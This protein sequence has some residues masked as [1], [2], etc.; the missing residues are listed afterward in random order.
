MGHRI[1]PLRV[2]LDIP[3]VRSAAPGLFFLLL[4]LLAP[5]CGGGSSSDPTKSK[6]QW[7]YAPGSL[8]LR[9]RADKMLNLYDAQG[10]TL[11]L[12]IYQLSDPNGFN[13]LVKTETGLRKLLECKDFDPTAVY[14]QQ[15]IVQPGEDRVIP[16]DR[17]EKATFVAV[18]A[19]YYE[20]A[21][22]RSTR[23]FQIPVLERDEGILTTDMV[24]TPGK[25]LVNLFLGP[26]G[27]Q[28]VG[29]D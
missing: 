13:N 17:A 3:R 7:T 5:G 18:V 28:S 10:H 23:L 14:F 6:P 1:P 2:R 16:L 9:F 19:G 24:R 8:E 25:L 15:L 12:C 26:L 27:I 22:Q 11:M 29:S 21:P 4:V 20:L